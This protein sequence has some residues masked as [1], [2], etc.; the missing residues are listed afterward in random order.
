M[1]DLLEIQLDPVNPVLSIT[2]E[3]SDNRINFAEE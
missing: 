1:D 3:N 2:N